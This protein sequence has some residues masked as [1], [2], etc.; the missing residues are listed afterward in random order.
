VDVAVTG[1]HGLIGSA[2]VDAL[3]RDGHR[4]RRLVRGELQGPDDVRWDPPAGTIDRAG[5]EGVGAVVH[6]AGAGIGDRRWSPERKQLVLESR[7]VST[8]L[9]ARALTELDAAPSVLVS[10]SAVGYYGDRGASVLEEDAAPGA[11]FTA[12]VCVAW[13]DATSPA[14]EAGIRVVRSRTG[15][16][17]ASHGGMLSRLLLPFRLGLGGRVG[18]GTQYLSWISLGD[19]VAGLRWMIDHQDLVGPVN[20]TAPNPVTNAEFTAALGR[21][22][23]RPTLLPTPLLPLRVVYGAELVQSLLLS[24]QRVVPSRLERSGFTHATPSI[25]GALDAV[26]HGPGTAGREP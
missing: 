3:R 6:L 4:V 20:L 19:A 14:A 11:D 1:A 17:L 10:G 23:H 7:T 8:R 16:V 5:L 25:A 18:P 22:L 15:I 9:L 2:L 21:A 26:L 13:E 12:E 24:G